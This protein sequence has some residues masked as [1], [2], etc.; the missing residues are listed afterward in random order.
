MQSGLNIPV[1]K[2]ISVSFFNISG[3]SPVCTEDS[4]IKKIASKCLYEAPNS[5][6]SSMFNSTPTSMYNKSMT[7]FAAFHS[8]FKEAVCCLAVQT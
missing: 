5:R 8:W 2:K 1:T 7:G 6:V 3:I 4:W